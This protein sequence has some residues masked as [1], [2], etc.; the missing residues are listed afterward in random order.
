MRTD[1]NSI[2]QPIAQIFLIF[3]N[4]FKQV[5]ILWASLL[6]ADLSI[7][8]RNESNKIIGACLNF[9]A[10]SDEAA[11][12]C[13]VSAFSRNIPTDDSEDSEII[14][15]ELPIEPSEPIEAVPMTVVEFIDAIE[16]PLKDQYLP[17]ALGKTIY[18]SLL[19]TAADLTPAENVKV[20]L[21]QPLYFHFLRIFIFRS[22][23]SWK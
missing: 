9:D 17:E 1:S 22:R 18:A 13:A 19:G 11:P 4:L 16:E 3:F 7:V 23:Y 21:L 14:I 12:L 20:R 10:R 8:I 6:Q 15:H 5:E 2:Y